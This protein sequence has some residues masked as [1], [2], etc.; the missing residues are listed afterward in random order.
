[1]PHHQ[2]VRL[3][4]G[5]VLAVL[6]V[7]AVAAV[8]ADDQDVL[9]AGAEVDRSVAAELV[10]DVGALDVAVQVLVEPGAD[11]RDAEDERRAHARAPHE[12][13]PSPGQPGLP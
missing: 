7:V 6:R 3:H 12:E 8:G 9:G 2:R 11:A 5:Q 13:P 1:V 4:G 10:V